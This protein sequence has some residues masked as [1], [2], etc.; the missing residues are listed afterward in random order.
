LASA[1]RTRLVIDAGNTNIAFAIYAGDARRGHWRISTDP[2]RTSDEYAVWL[3]QL[4]AIEGLTAAAVE[5]AIVASVVPGVTGALRRLCERYMGGPPLV[6]G[7]AGCR[8][9]IPVRLDRPEEIGADRLV[10][11]VATFERYGGPAIVVDFGTA[12]TFDVIGADGGYEGGAIAPGIHASMDALHAAAAKLP[13]VAIERP[14]RAIG[15]ATVPA[16]QS[17]VFWGYIGLIEG[18]IRRMSAEAAGL[19]GGPPTVIATG[20]LAPLFEPETDAI[21]AVDPDLTLRGLL[22]VARHHT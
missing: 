21:D 13:G 2:R 15:T 8:V 7:E 16:I 17:G 6:V 3:L 4:M 11:A 1:D 14:R 10:N 18:L 9:E 19:H 5:Q 20:G 12:T 22:S